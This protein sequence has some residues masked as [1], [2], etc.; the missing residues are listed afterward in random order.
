MSI[1]QWR[2]DGFS[3][4]NLSLYLYLGFFRKPEKL[5]SHTGSKWWPGCERWP[6]WPGDPVPCLA[7]AICPPDFYTHA[8]LN[9][10]KNCPRL[11]TE[12]SP[13]SVIIFAN[14]WPIILIFNPRR[15]TPM[16]EW[17]KKFKVKR[18]AVPKLEWKEI[19]SIKF[20]H[21]HFNAHHLLD[22]TIHDLLTKIQSRNQ[23]FVS[24]AATF[25]IN[26]RITLKP[27]GH[28]DDTSCLTV[29]YF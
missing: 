6:K 27:R 19:I 13:D 4:K 8:Y 26:R 29:A 9:N 24:F 10:Q 20:H 12:D 25:R 1:F 16:S 2:L 21:K 18:H 28:D 23:C 15:T 7:C 22:S 14:P 3:Q 5:G 11:R 17:R